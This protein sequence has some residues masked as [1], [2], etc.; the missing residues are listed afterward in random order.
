[1]HSAKYAVELNVAFSGDYYND[2]LGSLSTLW[3]SR[4]ISTELKD[5]LI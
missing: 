3:R 4:A 1:M 2:R 5:R